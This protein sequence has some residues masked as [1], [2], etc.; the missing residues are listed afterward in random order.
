MRRAWIKSEGQKVALQIVSHLGHSRAG[1]APGNPATNHPSTTVLGSGQHAAQGGDCH[2]RHTCHTVATR[3]TVVTQ[4][5]HRKAGRE[6]IF[7]PKWA[8]SPLPYPKPPPHVSTASPTVESSDYPLP[9]YSG[10][11]LIRDT[12]P[13]RTTI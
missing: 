11:S 12:P 8:E 5:P 4:S 13:P 6:E 3:H 9:G 10:P 7:C 2:S 1:S